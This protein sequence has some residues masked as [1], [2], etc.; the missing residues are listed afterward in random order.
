[1]SPAFGVERTRMFENWFHHELELK[2]FPDFS[3][4]LLFRRT[5]FNLFSISRWRFGRVE[6]RGTTPSGTSTLL[7][8]RSRWVICNGL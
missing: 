6:A 7:L 8:L 5:A 4:T 3:T 2:G 1:M